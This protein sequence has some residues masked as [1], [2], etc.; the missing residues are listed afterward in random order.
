MRKARDGRDGQGGQGRAGGAKSERSACENLTEEPAIRIDKWLWHARRIKTR[1]GAAKL[2]RE[3]K[4]RIN[5]EKISKPSRM[6]RPGD[7][8]TAMIGG[9]LAILEVIAPG[10]RRGPASEARELY[11]DMSPPAPSAAAA[12]R[13]KPSP[14][15]REPGSGRPTKRERRQIERLRSVAFY[16]EK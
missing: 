6:V 14:P 8:I 16:D 7:K 5:G 1:S 3:G 15:R 12:S 13:I 10:H 11:R 2:A 4:I 9:R